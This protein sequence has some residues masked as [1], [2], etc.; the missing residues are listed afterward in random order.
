MR[1][2]STAL[3]LVLLGLSLQTQAQMQ[4]HLIVKGDGTKVISNF[5]ATSSGRGN[6]WNWLAKQRDRRSSYDSYI[7]R[8]AAQYHVDPVLVR[9]VIQVESDFNP[10]CVSNKGARGL[11]QLMPETAREYG[12]RNVFEPEDNIRGGVHNLADLLG[13]YR[14]DLRRTLAAYNAGGGAVAK[15]SGIPPYEETMT[16]V[17]RALTV[18]Y[19]TPYGQSGGFGGGRGGRKLAGG[20]SAGVQPIVAMLPGMRYLGSR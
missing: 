4:V 16:Y 12:V 18:Y 9:A 1:T 13:R 14:G 7:D 6:D 10:H 11:M 20:F 2:A 3:V 19:G 17:K 8:Y 5:G 15:Y